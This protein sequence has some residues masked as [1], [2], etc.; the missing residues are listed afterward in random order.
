MGGESKQ[1]PESFLAAPRLESRVENL[2]ATGGELWEEW[3]GTQQRP[4][5]RRGIRHQCR[6][7]TRLTG[8]VQVFKT[9][10]LV[11]KASECCYF[12]YQVFLG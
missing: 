8:W 10:P 2:V 5:I 4:V 11:F 7:Q 9:F 12:I 3:R 1:G 6:G